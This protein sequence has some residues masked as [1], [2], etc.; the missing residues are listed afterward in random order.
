VTPRP[1]EVAFP[2]SDLAD[3]RRRLELTR[4]AEPPAGTSGWARGTEPSYLKELVEYW[5]DG[6]DWRKQEAQLNRFQ[7]FKARAGGFDLHFVHQ[8][9]R[10]P[11]PLPILLLNGWPSSVF[12]HLPLIPLLTDPPD[13]GDSFTVVAPSLPGYTLSFTP[14]GASPTNVAAAAACAEL[15]TGV[16]GHERFAVVG[17]DVGATLTTRLAFAHTEH[18]LGI[19]YTFLSAGLGPET[20]AGLGPDGE[21]FSEELRA[22][23]RDESGY[24]SIQG[25]RPATLAYGLHDSPVGLAAWIVE[26]MIGWSDRS[27]SAE[28]PYAEDD[29]LANVTLYWLTGSIGSSFWSYWS[30]AHGDWS[31]RDVM[32]QGARLLPPAAYVLCP[33]DTIRA[34]RGVAERFLDVRRFSRLPA[35]GHFPGFE[36][37][38]ALAAEIS[39]FFRAL[40]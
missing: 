28:H 23:R 16:L 6:F 8:Q 27:G 33:A 39:T 13:P 9:G 31:V 40:R 12:E 11:H 4:W 30:R 36:M 37:P 3:L 2:D 21:R 1:F 15:M 14:G 25:S 22:W 5:R 18:V 7:Q 20:V 38:S 26:K 34:P 17:A 10:G 32:A 19:L 35:G 24:V 29:L